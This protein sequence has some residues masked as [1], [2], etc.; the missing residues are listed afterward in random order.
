MGACAV[1]KFSDTG[2]SGLQFESEPQ[3]Y[4]ARVVMQMVKQ[5]DYLV[6]CH[7]AA[8]EHVT[9]V[10]CH[11]MQTHTIHRQLL[12]NRQVDY[13]SQDMCG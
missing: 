8:A 7:S 2:V 13:R 3:N 4:S 5:S 9:H 11:G 6:V 10:P 1:G 12:H